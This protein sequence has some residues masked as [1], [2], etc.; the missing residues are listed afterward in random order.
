MSFTSS[1]IAIEELAKIDP[2]VSVIIDVQAGLLI[3]YCSIPL[4]CGHQNCLS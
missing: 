3:I 4:Y 1:I 2:A